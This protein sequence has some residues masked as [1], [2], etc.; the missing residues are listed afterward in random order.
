MMMMMMMMM[1]L[2]GCER[3]GRGEGV[4]EGSERQGPSYWYQCQP[5]SEKAVGILQIKSKNVYVVAQSRQ[6]KSGYTWTENNAHPTP[7][8]TYQHVEKSSPSLFSPSRIGPLEWPT[9]LQT[10][11]HLEAVESEDV[12]MLT[13]PTASKIVIVSFMRFFYLSSLCAI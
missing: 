7:T 5:D 1:L 9:R 6:A 8:S 4:E 11:R 3:K 12:G 10:N 13:S 2:S